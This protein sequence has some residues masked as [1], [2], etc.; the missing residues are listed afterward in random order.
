M[1]GII[2]N[3]MNLTETDRARAAEER[4]EQKLLPE[5]R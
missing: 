4:T 3:V 1:E 5:Q 2:S